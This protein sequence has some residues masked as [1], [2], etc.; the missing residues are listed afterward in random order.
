V[1]IDD[2]GRI[3]VLDQVEAAVKVFSSQGDYLEHVAR[4]GSGPGEL[5]MP[6]Q[7]FSMPGG[8]LYIVDPMKRGFVIYD[9][10]LNY[11]G[12]DAL[13]F[14]NPPFQGTAVSDSQYVGYKIDTDAADN[15]IISRRTVALYTLGQADWDDVFWHDSIVVNMDE[16]MEDPS[17]LILDLIDPLSICGYEGGIFFTLKDSE[18]YSVTRWDA[19]GEEL[20]Q[21]TMDLPPVAKTPEEIAAEST[22]VTSYVSRFAGGGGGM[23]FEFNPDPYK[24][25]ID[26]VA[27]GPDG[28]LWVKRGTTTAPFFDVFDP[29]SGELLGHRVFPREGWSWNVDV[30]RNG[31][32][33][34][35]EDPELGYQQ[36]Y[37]LKQD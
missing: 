29:D 14:Q 1:I 24:D 17:K 30:S 18:E 28:N 35:E 25:M 23:P 31:I 10:S 5:Q 34:W 19:M 8:E 12:E 4:R 2:D 36:L 13:W 7:M 26:N 21:I 9:D 33:A 32:A 11:V 27:I 3:I 20:L 22:F 6:W 37:I 16:L 15:S